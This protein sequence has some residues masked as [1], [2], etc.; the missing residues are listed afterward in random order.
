LIERSYAQQSHCRLNLIFQDA[1]CLVDTCFAKGYGVE[2]GPAQP[3]TLSPERKGFYNIG[4]SGDTTIDNYL[5]LFEN[6]RAVLTY[7]EEGFHR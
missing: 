5:A 3:D 1:Y 6:F 2:K 7:G 4:A